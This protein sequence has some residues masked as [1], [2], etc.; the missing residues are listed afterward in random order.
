VQLLFLRHGPAKQRGGWKGDDRERPLTAEGRE[1]MR[2]VTA[3]MTRLGLKPDIILSSPLARALQTAE[4]VA[5]GLAAGGA[6][7]QEE[8]LCP[9]F[10]SEK[11]AGIVR[12]HR[13]AKTIMLVG[14]EPDFSTTISTLIG[15]GAIVCKKGGLARVDVEDPSLKRAELVW[16]LPPRALALEP[17]S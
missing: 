12:D 4:I 16:L 8:R 5:G 7:I 10:S 2:R 14:H 9:G 13:D 15:G 6:V 11:L 17:G 3:T 1:T